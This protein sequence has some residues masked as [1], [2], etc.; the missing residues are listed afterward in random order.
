M[1]LVRRLPAPADNLSYR[2]FFRSLVKGD[3]LY[4][5]VAEDAAV[6]HGFGQTVQNVEGVAREHAF[7]K[8]NDIPVVVVLGGL[9]QNDAEFLKRRTGQWLGHR[10][11]F[12]CKLA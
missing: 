7:P 9:D 10:F 8:A 12:S 1:S 2:E 3:D 11:M 6:F 5:K 4:R